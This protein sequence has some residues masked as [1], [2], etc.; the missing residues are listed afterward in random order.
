MVT[1]RGR[2]ANT[3]CKDMDFPNE[4]SDDGGTRKK[5]RRLSGLFGKVKTQKRDDGKE[6]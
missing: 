2:D 1:E 5:K 4:I 3:C 6:K